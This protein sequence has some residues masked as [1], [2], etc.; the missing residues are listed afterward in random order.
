M[1]DFSFEPRA[2]DVSWSSDWRPENPDRPE[3]PELTGADFCLSCFRADVQLVVHGVD[4][5]L[6]TPGLPVV[7]FALMLEYARREL[8]ARSGIAVETSVTS[9][10]FSLSRGPE[11]VTLTTNYASAVAESTWDE[12]RHLTDRAKSEAFRLITTAHPELRDHAWLRETVG[13]EAPPTA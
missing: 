8:E 10:V 13:T 1:I 12:L 7:D 5:S 4:L 2:D 3:H 9:H 11:V 6:R